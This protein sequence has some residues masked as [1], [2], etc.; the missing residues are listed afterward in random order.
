MRQVN[1]NKE[2][3]KKLFNHSRNIK[4][5]KTDKFWNNLVL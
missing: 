4:N 1:F 5:K 3:N 2:I